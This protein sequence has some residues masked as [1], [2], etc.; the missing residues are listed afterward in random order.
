MRTLTEGTTRTVDA[1]APVARPYKLAHLVIRTARLAE[2]RAFYLDVLGAEVVSEHEGLYCGMTY[3]EEHHRLALVAIP[4]A[5]TTEAGSTFSAGVLNNNEDTDLGDL[6]FSASP[7][8]EHV[9]FTYATLSELVHSYVRLREHGITPAFCVNHGPTVS[10]YYEDP[11]AN[12]VELQIDSMTLDA[13]D[14]YLRSEVAMENVIGWPFDPE[15]LVARFEAGEP[16]N[17]LALG[18]GKPDSGA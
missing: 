15:D 10:L 16:I 9:A 14:E 4:E 3:D 11:D 17:E 12:K 5:P 7:G 1:D 6:A 2:M 18:I 8:L 13:A